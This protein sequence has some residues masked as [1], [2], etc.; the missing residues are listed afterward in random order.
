MFG[1]L[2]FG[3]SIIL[4]DRFER[5]RDG[6]LQHLIEAMGRRALSPHSA[7]IRLLGELTTGGSA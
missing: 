4:R 1:H 2:F 5:N 7:A 6:H 3:G